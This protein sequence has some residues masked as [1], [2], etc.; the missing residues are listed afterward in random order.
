M[1]ANIFD[2]QSPFSTNVSH[3][4]SLSLSHT[5]T[6]TNTNTHTHTHTHTHFL[7][8]CQCEKEIDLDNMSKTKEGGWWRKIYKCD[9]NYYLFKFDFFGENLQKDILLNYF[10]SPYDSLVLLFGVSFSVY[11]TALSLLLSLSLSLSISELHSKGRLLALPTN[12]KHGLR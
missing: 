12:I 2:N 9:V 10:M 8:V 11:S 5:H 4:P 7:S 1:S 6:H 3:S